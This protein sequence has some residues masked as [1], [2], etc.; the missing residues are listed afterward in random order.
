MRYDIQQEVS[1]TW[2]TIFSVTSWDRAVYLF[3]EYRAL[4]YSMRI[5]G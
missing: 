4:G 2:V 5:N 3:N 1:G